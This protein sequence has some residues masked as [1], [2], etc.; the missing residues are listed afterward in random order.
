MELIYFYEPSLYFG[1][2]I[3]WSEKETPKLHA[4]LLKLVFLQ[5]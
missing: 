2:Y 3:V 5:I 1:G 4:F